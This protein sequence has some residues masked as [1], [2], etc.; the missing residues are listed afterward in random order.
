MGT[1]D[2]KKRLANLHKHGIDLND[3]DEVFAA[4]V[5]TQEDRSRDYPEERMRSIGWFRGDIVVL[6]WAP[7]EDSPRFISCR[8]A[9]K[10][11]RKEYLAN[12]LP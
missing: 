1:C 4:P 9:N 7:P 10:H 12:V 2:P 6:I 8:K 5:V 3:V 11:E